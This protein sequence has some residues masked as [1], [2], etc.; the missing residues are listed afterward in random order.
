MLF[1]T[2][3][4]NIFINNPFL[5]EKINKYKI[6]EVVYSQLY[7]G[8]NSFID[9]YKEE[10]DKYKLSDKEIEQLEEDKNQYYIWE[11]WNWMKTSVIIWDYDYKIHQDHDNNEF[12]VEHW[13][14]K[15]YDKF[16]YPIYFTKDEEYQIKQKLLYRTV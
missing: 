5:E 14:S 3:N 12:I 13:Y 9:D 10:S 4:Y 6:V 1:K 16:R 11:W 8:D 15:K 2:D 7:S